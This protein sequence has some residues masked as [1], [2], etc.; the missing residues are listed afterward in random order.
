MFSI[1]H[2]AYGDFK[3]LP[4]KTTTDKAL[5][6]KAFTIV[7]NPKF[8]RYQRGLASMVYVFLMKRLQ[9]VLIKMKSYK[10]MN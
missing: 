9:L 5:H 10:I 2:M 7:K 8:D 4:R 1:W 6:Y 3:D